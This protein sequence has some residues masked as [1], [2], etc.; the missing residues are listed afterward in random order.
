MLGFLAGRALRQGDY[1]GSL[2]Y[3]ER[4]WDAGRETDTTTRLALADAIRRQALTDPDSAG[5]ELQRA[6]GHAI[7]AMHERR[8]WDGP[9]D[10]AL[11]AA[12][13]ILIV[14]GDWTAMLDAALPADRGGQA[15]PREAASP[16]VARRAAVAAEARGEGA[17]LEFFLQALPD[18]ATGAASSRQAARAGPAGTRGRAGRGLA[19][20]AGGFPRRRVGRRVR[21]GPGPAGGMARPRGRAARPGRPAP[22]RGRD[23]ARSAPGPLRPPGRRARPAA[24]HRHPGRAGGRRPGRPGRPGPRRRRGDRRVRAAAGTVAAPP[25][26]Q[27]AARQPARARRPGRRGRRANRVADQ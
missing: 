17:A 14:T 10:L 5:R 27:P 19:A 8:R 13:D 18:S 1:L 2:D 25:R 4:Q 15:L 20:A 22:G 21:R 26:P 6:L 11:A 16:A 12:L 24:R 23:L 3:R 7:A 9:S